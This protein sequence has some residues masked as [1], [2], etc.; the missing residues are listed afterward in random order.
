MREIQ[1]RH[2][3]RRAAKLACALP[4]QAALASITFQPNLRESAMLRIKRRLRNSAIRLAGALALSATLSLVVASAAI[5]GSI[6]SAAAQV[7]PSRPITMI[8]P[9]AAGGSTDAIGRIMAEG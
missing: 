2:M 7:F 8:V 9:Y 4:R 6:G 5:L 3:S 1:R